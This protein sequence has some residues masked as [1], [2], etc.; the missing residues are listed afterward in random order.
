M[1]GKGK[2]RYVFAS[3]NTSQGFYTFIPDL[4]AGLARVYILKGAAGTGKST[5]IRLL[6]E[7][8]YE[9]G[10]EVEFWVS[11]VDGI[12]PDGVYI[13]QLRAAVINGSL[14][15]PVDPEYPGSHAEIIN[16][17][18]YWDK[19]II[20]HKCHNI[21]TQVEEFRRHH[22]QAINAL[23]GVARLQEEVKKAAST[24]LNL[25]K[26]SDL[27]EKV[28]GDIMENQIAEKH[29]FASV[30]T[31]EGMINY[32][33]EISSSC[34]KRYIF[35]GPTSSGKSTVIRE[36]ADRA[37]QRGYLLEYYHCGI[38]VENI[39]MVIVPNLQLALIDAGN[40]ETGIKPWDIIIDMN[41]C[42]DDGKIDYNDAKA[43]DN[44]RGIESLLLTAQNELKGADGAIK[45]IKK[46][47]SAAMDFEALDE[48][49]NQV[50]EEISRRN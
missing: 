44:I 20:N 35:K 41:T 26:I 25:E 33:D 34:R 30:V 13:P 15:T 2:L 12:S 9:Q 40:I 11:S 21:D 47:Y 3:S 17:G 37:R 45:E 19:E 10:Y 8:L 23:K 14:P 1:N 50:R 24:R 31:A 36:V 4:I 43:N 38:D 48:R 5:F 18:A 28:A 39:V 27:I 32:L 7:S 16:L 22:L 46:I 49:R 29:Y 6:G 42:L